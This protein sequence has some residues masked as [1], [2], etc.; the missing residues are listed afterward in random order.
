MFG[1]FFYVTHP[2]AI[3]L[4]LLACVKYFVSVL[5]EQGSNS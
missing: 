1:K 4:K 3:L 2:F 5:S